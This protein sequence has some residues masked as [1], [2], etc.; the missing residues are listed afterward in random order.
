MTV[1]FDDVWHQI[2]LGGL[3]NKKVNVSDQYGHYE[4]PEMMFYLQALT[5]ISTSS[6]IDK[7]IIRTNHT[8]VSNVG[9]KRWQSLPTNFIFDL[10]CLK[11]N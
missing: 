6:T 7:N 2:N 3:L 8:N 9:N 1:N 5:F 11:C 10:M 4:L